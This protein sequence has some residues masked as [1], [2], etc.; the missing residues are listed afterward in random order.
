MEAMYNLLCITVPAK[1]LYVNS[2]IMPLPTQI[3]HSSDTHPLLI[4][5]TSA[6]RLNNVKISKQQPNEWLF[7]DRGTMSVSHSL[8]T[9]ILTPIPYSHQ[10]HSSSLY[11]ILTPADLLWSNS[12][13]GLREGTPG[14]GNSAQWWAQTT[15]TV[16]WLM[17]LSWWYHP[18]LL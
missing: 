18:V 1:C 6:M 13:R 11:P 2:N 17:S 9:P 10:N 14:D 16:S 7:N 12:S 3:L 8:L 15:L 4:P 5:H